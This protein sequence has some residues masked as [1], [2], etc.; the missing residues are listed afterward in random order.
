M[1]SYQ[2]LCNTIMA[3]PLIDEEEY[4]YDYHTEYAFSVLHAAYPRVS[5]AII[6]DAIMCDWNDQ[7]TDEENITNCRYLE[8]YA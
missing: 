5:A 1:N 7:L 2:E 4:N 6:S 3:Y 8:E